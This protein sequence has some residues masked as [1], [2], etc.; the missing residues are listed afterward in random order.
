MPATRLVKK[1]TP[2]VETSLA[3]VAR[4][5]KLTRHYLKEEMEAR[6]INQSEA[7]DSIIP[8]LTIYDAGFNDPNR[9]IA[10]I[11]MLGPTGVGKTLCVETL[12]GILHGDTKKLLRIDCG[13]FEQSHEVA[14]L[15]GSPPGYLGHRETP[16]LLTNK[17]VQDMRSESCDISLILF[18]EVEKAH[19][20]FQKALLSILDKGELTVGDNSVTDFK[21][22]IIFFTSNLGAEE[23][24]KLAEPTIGFGGPRI[25]SEEVYRRLESIGN[26]A[27]KKKFTPEFVNRLD[28]IVTFHP[29][30]EKAISKIFRISLDNIRELVYIKGGSDIFLVLSDGAE[31]HLIHK[32]FSKLYGARELNRVMRKELIHP[33]AEIISDGLAKNNSVIR[34]DCLNSKLVFNIFKKDD[35]EKSLLLL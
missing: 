3:V 8:Y 23:M 32:G 31:Q 24:Q 33:V 34:V 20:S 28:E 29:L 35:L 1:K 2:K 7:I 10:G 19:N 14:K 9:P 27:V 13:Q 6:L 22:S 5:K 11:F 16:P 18:D 25:V 21:K 12:A 4:P 17:R 30:S 26:K 15:L